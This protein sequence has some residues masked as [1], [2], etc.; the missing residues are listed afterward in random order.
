MSYTRKSEYCI[1]ILIETKV[2]KLE[3]LEL[4]NL[5][6]KYFSLTQVNNLNK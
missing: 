6:Y 1:L 4:I 2:V 5:L 3:Q